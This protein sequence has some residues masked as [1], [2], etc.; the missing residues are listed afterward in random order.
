MTQPH[1]P[2]HRAFID[3]LNRLR[4]QAGNPPLSHLRRLSRRRL[5]NG[6]EGREL[7]PS[8]TQEIL[9]GKRRHL[10]QWSWVV[11]FVAACHE[12]AREG[13]L[14]LGPMDLAA[15]SA[16]L[17]HA[18]HGDRPAIRCAPL[19]PA[20]PD[21]LTADDIVQSHLE[22]HGRVAARLAREAM[23]GDTEACF[24]LALFTLL[25]GWSLDG[26]TWLARAADAGH[27]AALELQNADDVRAQA[28]EVA[29]RHACALEAGGPTRASI[30]R[31][32][33]R[34][35]AETGH[36]GATAKLKVAPAADAPLTASDF[37]QPLMS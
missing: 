13:N 5:P 1:N 26:M 27:E 23:N 18:R 11:S 25:R 6:R 17:L 9:S 32:F 22:T 21:Q 35:A 12:A 31:C 16:R 15:W 20:G 3:Q 29:Y 19:V 4:E 30:A 24:H 2:A 36:P 7:A 34:L 8:T 37:D 33:Y 10:P 28:A 14:D